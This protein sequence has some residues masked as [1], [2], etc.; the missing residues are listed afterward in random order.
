MI[1]NFI[2]TNYKIVSYSK[3]KTIFKKA[4]VVKNLKKSNYFFD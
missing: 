4:F 2:T 3:Q 1:P